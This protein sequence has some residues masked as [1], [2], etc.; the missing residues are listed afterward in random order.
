MNKVLAAHRAGIYRVIL[1]KS[2]E[3][4]LRDLPKDVLDKMQFVFAERF[5]DVLAQAIPTLQILNKVA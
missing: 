4:D 1:P 2:N 3:N 5:E